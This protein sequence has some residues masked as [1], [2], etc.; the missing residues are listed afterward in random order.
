MPQITISISSPPNSVDHSA[1]RL[2]PLPQDLWGTAFGT[3][4]ERR[5]RGHPFAS[6]P[7]PARTDTGGL[8]GA[9]EWRAPEQ[10]QSRHRGDGEQPVLC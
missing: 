1:A 9:E 5:E 10:G 3:A 6:V 7:T 4:P 2:S 8:P